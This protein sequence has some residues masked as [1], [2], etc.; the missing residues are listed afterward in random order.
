MIACLPPDV[1]A[2]LQQQ[3][4]STS[5]IYSFDQMSVQVLEEEIFSIHTTNQ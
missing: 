4:L 1:E 5:K 2:D 3:L